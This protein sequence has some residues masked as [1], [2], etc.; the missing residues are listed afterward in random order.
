M[1]FRLVRP[2]KR[3]GS[4]NQYFV[5]RIPVDVREQLIGKTLHFPLGDSV[6]AVTVSP[7]AQAIRFS[8]RTNDPS[9][10]KARTAAAD[11]YLERVLQALRRDGEGIVTTLTNEQATALAGRL[12]RSWANGE[13]H[14]RTT[15]VEEI[16]KAER[17]EGGPRM[18]LVAHD[19]LEDVLGFEAALHHLPQPNDEPLDETTLGAL[20]VNLGP[21]IDHI[22]L[23][24]GI[25]RVDTQSRSLLLRA[26]WLALRDALEKRKRNAQGDYT[27]DPK[28][29]RFPAWKAPSE[30]ANSGATALC[31]T[32]APK[33]PSSDASGFVSLRS[34]VV[35]W[36]RESKAIGLKASTHESHN[37]AMETF[38][39]FLGHDDA[40]RVTVSDVI[41]FKDH[42]L[43]TIE[44]ANFSAHG[45]EV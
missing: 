36:W 27:P 3:G 33:Q 21:T 29:E 38:V 7:K 34:L 18:R 6:Q 45:V 44:S 5:R 13:G 1:L 8:L 30:A 26:F 2:M 24:E 41:G 32:A 43:A 40:S 42:R 39:A 19:P 11:Q 20:E 15:A 9:E 12:Y 23:S 10:V 22:L 14:E 35:G 25:A 31:A 16:P 4:Q 28:S 37:H 17:M